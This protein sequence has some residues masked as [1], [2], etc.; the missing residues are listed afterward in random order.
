MKPSFGHCF[1]GVVLLL[2]TALVL[3]LGCGQKNQDSSDSGSKIPETVTGLG[4]LEPYDGIIHLNAAPSDRVV[5][6]IVHEGDWVEPGDELVIMESQAFRKKEQELA[7]TQVKEAEDR[8]A[9]V[10]ANGAVQ[11][12]EF[13]FKLVRTKEGLKD[14]V[15][16]LKQKVTLLAKQERAAWNSWKSMDSLTAGSIPDQDV[17]RQELAAESAKVELDNAQVMLKKAEEAL[18]RSKEESQIQRE[19]L[20]GTIQRAR[21]EIPLETAKGNLALAKQRYEAGRIKAPAAG[22]ILTILTRRGEAPGA[23]PLLQ[24]GDTR[25]LAIIAEVDEFDSIYVQ[26]KQPV[27][28]TSRAFNGLDTKKVWGVVES[29]GTTVSRN[30]VNDLNPAAMSDRRVV[31]VKV[32]LNLTG[33]EDEEVRKRLARLINLQVNVAIETDGP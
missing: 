5:T 6:W 20:E 25:H 4:R 30:S 11:V 9:A 17:K 7:A 14:D 8:L 26:K 27:R 28:I 24:M 13:E 16:L 29:I 19:V 12:R 33:P 23:R 18:L 15:K 2:L 32:K 3:L 10:E 1:R 22:K 21:L 31:E